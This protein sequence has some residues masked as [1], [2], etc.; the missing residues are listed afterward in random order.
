MD[1]AFPRSPSYGSE[2]I[3]RESAFKTGSELRRDF[4]EANRAGIAGGSNS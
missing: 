4:R 3:L 1:G 2:C